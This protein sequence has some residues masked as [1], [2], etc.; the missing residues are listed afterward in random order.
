MPGNNWNKKSEEDGLSY[1]NTKEPYERPKTPSELAQD[2]AK[3]LEP[4]INTLI[5]RIQYQQTYS[6]DLNATV[7][8]TDEMDLVVKEAVK[9]LKAAGWIVSVDNVPTGN[10]RRLFIKPLET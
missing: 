6:A 8:I 3:S 2:I 9:R 10:P 7:Q 1:V 4:K 5:K